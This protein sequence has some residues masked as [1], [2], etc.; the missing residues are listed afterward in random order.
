MV[1]EQRILMEVSP[2]NMET[3]ESAK[4]APLTS[5]VTEMLA[6]LVAMV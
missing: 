4:V 6:D 2:V 5:T 1:W 3:N